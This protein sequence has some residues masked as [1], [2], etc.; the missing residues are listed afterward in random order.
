M[1]H[2]PLKRLPRFPEKSRSHEARRRVRV[3][4]AKPIPHHAGSAASLPSPC[5]P[6]LLPPRRNKKK[7]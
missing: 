3:P 1:P 4:P 6:V 7:D 2:H 5:L